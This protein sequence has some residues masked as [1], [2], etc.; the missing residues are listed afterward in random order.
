[1]R[2]AVGWPWYLLMSTNS[3]G[4]SHA[5]QM[6]HQQMTVGEPPSGVCGAE[7]L[8]IKVFEDLNIWKIFGSFKN[9]WLPDY[10][11][12]SNGNTYGVSIWRFCIHSIDVTMQPWCVRPWKA[13]TSRSGD[14]LN[15]RIYKVPGLPKNYN[16]KIC[17]SPLKIVKTYPPC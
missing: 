13:E 14:V 3:H 8:N 9:L 11:I 10:G 17:H 1:M 5:S 4:K 15:N 16:W 12:T 6:M 2:K 7:S